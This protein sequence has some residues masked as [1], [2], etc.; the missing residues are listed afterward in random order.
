MALDTATLKDSLNELEQIVSIMDRTA[1]GFHDQGSQ[2]TAR[3][4]LL[5]FKEK[6]VLEK[7]SR[8]KAILEADLSA[9]LSRDEY[10]SWRDDNT[11]PW[12]PPYGKS[13]EEIVEL[14]RAVCSLEEC[15]DD[16]HYEDRNSWEKSLE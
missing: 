10:D 1:S 15:V 7:L 2:A 5:Y 8:I 6:N 16:E 13:E 9:A 3:A 4:L 11:D 14:F 12:T